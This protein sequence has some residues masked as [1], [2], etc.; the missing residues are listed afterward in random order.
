LNPLVY[1]KKMG[2][3]FAVDLP[4]ILP[5]I[6]APAQ[7][8]GVREMACPGWVAFEIQFCSQRADVT[9]QNGNLTG[10]AA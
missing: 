6:P 4:V 9:T 10:T 2:D 8:K 7:K 1:I 5:M 3:P